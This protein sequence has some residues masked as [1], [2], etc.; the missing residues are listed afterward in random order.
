MYINNQK[1][2]KFQFKILLFKKKNGI[3]RLHT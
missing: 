2:I 3:F 1:C